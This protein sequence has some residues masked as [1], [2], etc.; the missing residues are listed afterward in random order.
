[1]AQGTATLRFT[2][3]LLAEALQLTLALT[4]HSEGQKTAQR[5]IATALETAFERPGL[6]LSPAT[7]IA[8]GLW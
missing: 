1:M 2:P 3:P 6:R 8:T 5:E 4:P 7:F